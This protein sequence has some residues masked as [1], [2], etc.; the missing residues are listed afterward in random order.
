MSVDKYRWII[1]FLTYLCMLGFAFTFQSP[2]PILTLIAQELTLTHAEA[3]L[4]MSLFSL[5]AIFLAIFVGLLSDRLGPFKIGLISLILMVVGTL[6]FAISDNLIYAGLGRI[7]AGVGAVTISIIATHILA[8]W[9]KGS[10][11]GAA[12]GIFHTAMPVGTIICFTTFGMLGKNFGW[13]LPI[14]V[15]V[16]IVI[17]VL[18][19]FLLLYKPA[20]NQSQNIPFEKEGLFSN[21]LKVGVLPWLIG[22]CWMWFSLVVIS[23]LSFAPDFFISN[24]YSIEFAGFLASLLMWGSLCLS[25]IIGHLVDKVGN[26][27]LFIIVGG[28]ILALAIYFVTRSTDF[29]FLMGLMAVAVAFIPAPIYSLQSKILKTK[30]LGL[31]FGILST[32]SSIGIFSGPYI[33]GLVRDKTNS[34]KMSFIFLS[35]IAMLIAFTAILV[36]VKRRK[37]S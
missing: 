27:D 4:L 34:Y 7:I 18:V 30:N 25:P 32:L 29:F 28:I 19:S 35:T 24:G 33:T 37:E 26:H 9:F 23:F 5:P 1:L 20:P 22:F 16:I 31:G 6:I 17:V 13:R 15:T 2:P 21:L 8:L 14:F 3:G 11:V 10:E 12:M 36:R